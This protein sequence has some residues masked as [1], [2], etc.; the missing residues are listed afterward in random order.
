MNIQ[1][2]EGRFPRVS[3]S[4]RA[5][6]IE[7]HA[8]FAWSELSH[9]ITR[10]RAAVTQLDGSLHAPGGVEDGQTL[11]DEMMQAAI[12]LTDRIEAQR[13]IQIEY[14]RGLR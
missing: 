9:A 4:A 3:A 5:D 1:I 14:R 10:V 12:T 2:T 7:E 13:A 11:L 8:N 6:E